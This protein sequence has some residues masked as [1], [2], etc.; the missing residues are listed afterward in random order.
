ML[1]RAL[2]VNADDPE[3]LLRIKVRIPALHGEA[4]ESDWAWPCVVPGWPVVFANHADP[5]GTLTHTATKSVPA[6]GDGVWVMFE[7]D[8]PTHPVWI[9]T[10]RRA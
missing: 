9:G 7:N 4:G 5:E 1:M 8:D 2:C 3:G 6:P 10:W